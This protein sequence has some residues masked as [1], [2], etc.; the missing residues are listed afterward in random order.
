MNRSISGSILTVICLGLSTSLPAPAR[1]DNPPPPAVGIYRYDVLPNDCIERTTRIVGEYEITT[2]RECAYPVKEIRVPDAG[3]PSLGDLRFLIT[4]T[5]P[6]GEVVLEGL[7][8]P[9][10]IDQFVALVRD[11][12]YFAPLLGRWMVRRSVLRLLQSDWDLNR[13]VAH[14]PDNLPIGVYRVQLVYEYRR[15]GRLTGSYI[16]GSNT[17]LADV[18]Q[19]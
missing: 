5:H 11:D 8:G 7:I 2:V 18:R 15:L 1:A 13:I 14:L 10:R 3:D 6:G 12:I 9:R 17:V 4:R 16:M 19:Q